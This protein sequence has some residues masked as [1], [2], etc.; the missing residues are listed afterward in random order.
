[1]GPPRRLAHSRAGG[2]P[3]SLPIARRLQLRTE[4]PQNNSLSLVA[5]PAQAIGC[6]NIRILLD[7]DDMSAL[8]LIGEK[9]QG[10]REL[11]RASAPTA[12]RY[13]LYSRHR[14]SSRRI[15]TPID[16]ARLLARSRADS[17]HPC[18]LSRKR[19]RRFLRIFVPSH[20]APPYGTSS[21]CRFK[22]RPSRS[23][24]SGTRRPIVRSIAFSTTKV[25]TPQ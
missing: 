10:M 5:F 22:S 12:E 24:S 25:T 20:R 1:M 4:S 21:P 2:F 18:P 14:G 13:N 9:E 8:L 15:R 6:A 16:A 11:A 23:T 7:G 19:E 3:I 17:P